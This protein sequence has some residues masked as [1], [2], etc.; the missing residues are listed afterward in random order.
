MRCDEQR[1]GEA[2]LG[3]GAVETIL[4]CDKGEY[5]SYAAGDDDARAPESNRTVRRSLRRSLRWVQD[6]RASLRGRPLFALFTVVNLVNYMD[7]GVIPG[8][9]EEFNAFIEQTMFTDRPDVFLGILQSGFILGF[10]IACVIFARLAR[11]RSPFSLM[12]TGLAVWCFASVSAGMARPAG[13]YTFLLVARLLSGVG[14]AS[15]VTVVPP[16]ITETA[17]PGERGIWLALFYT[18]QP[19]GAG[20]GYVYGS[21]M[22]TSRLGWPWAF[23]LEAILMAPLAFACA[24]V[25]PESATAVPNASDYGTPTGRTSAGAGRLISSNEYGSQTS[26][27]AGLGAGVGQDQSDLSPGLT[28]SGSSLASSATTPRRGSLTLRSRFRQSEIDKH[29]DAGSARLLLPLDEGSAEGPPKASST[30]S[31][32]GLWRGE[33]GGGRAAGDD[34]ETSV[35]WQKHTA[36]F[37]NGGG[38]CLVMSPSRVVPRAFEGPGEEGEQEGVGWAVG[39]PA[40]ATL[41]SLNSGG[42]VV[43]VSSSPFDE[44]AGETAESIL[45]RDV[46]KI[47]DRCVFCL[48]VLG[49][50]ATAA[51]SAGMSTFGTGFVTSLEFL[52]SETAA[53]ATFGGVICTAGLAGTPAGGALIDAADP[54]GRLGDDKK[55]ALVLRQAATLMC[56]AT[57]LLV[58]ATAQSSLIPFLFFFFFGAALLFATSAHSN[59]AI[60]LASPKHL[61]PLSIA[62]NSILLH[63]LGDVPSPTVI[64]WMKDAYAPHCVAGGGVGA[65]VA[66][67]DGLG[68]AGIDAGTLDGRIGLATTGR[69]T[70]TSWVGAGGWGALGGISDACRSERRGLH[71]TLFLTVAWLLWTCLFFGLARAVQDSAM[72]H[73]VVPA[74]WGDIK[75]LIWKGL[76]R[77]GWTRKRYYKRRSGAVA[78]AALGSSSNRNESSRSWSKRWWRQGRGRGRGRPGTLSI[79]DEEDEDYEHALGVSSTLEEALLPSSPISP[80]GQTQT[81]PSVGS[82]FS[83]RV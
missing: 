78:P 26:L 10:S 65:G 32:L 64:G 27:G 16:L 77:P 35:N 51:V 28:V 45:V 74:T 17:P 36:E 43:A 23:F 7:R 30:S 37:G 48:V 73:G 68:L 63:A 4:K 47:A 24:L 18:A 41:G 57:V 58:A 46:L 6:A 3:A 76:L 21:L 14:E 22:A 60:M 20:I 13:S 61:R 42:P 72:E 29:A 40:V 2:G 50:A 1:A 49:G 83:S 5:I 82:S 81:S 11:H 15:F 53:A 56:G 38:A 59:L 19:V 66:V 70:D 33:E 34:A 9:S 55:L 71:M 69:Q 80:R 25:P 62:V 67:A 54:E 79:N 8:G 39:E 44:R 31:L 75:G 52:T 12:A